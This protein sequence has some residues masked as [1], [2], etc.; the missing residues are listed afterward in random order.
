MRSIT[1]KPCK[2]GIDPCFAFR[3][4]CRR[5]PTLDGKEFFPVVQDITAVGAVYSE[6]GLGT[7]DQDSFRHTLGICRDLGIG[8]SADFHLLPLNMDIGRNQDFLKR[9]KPDAADLLAVWYAFNPPPEGHSSYL[10]QIF[11]PSLY[12][13]SPDHFK[14]RA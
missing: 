13:C 4:I 11:N 2:K 9:K 14:E 10:P 5:T 3:E 8:I 6:K 12:V 7:N 1:F